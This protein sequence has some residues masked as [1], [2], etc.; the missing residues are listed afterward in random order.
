M[1]L[2]AIFIFGVN[3]V[4][5]TIDFAN[6]YALFLAISLTLNFEFGYT[7]I[8]NFGKVLF[9]AA[10]A[11]IS[12]SISG[13]I[14]A[15]AFNINSHGDIITF[16]AQVITQANTFISGDALFAVSIILFSLLLAGTIGATFGYLASYPAIR[17]R[18]DY[19][20]MLLLA[21]AQFFQIFLSGY[22]PLVGG[23]QGI[24]VPDPYS[25]WAGL[26]TGVRDLVAMLVIGAFAIIV[27]IYVER[28][29]RSPL[30]RTLRALRDNED[31]SK[32]LGKD[33]VAIRKRVLVIASAISGMAGALLTFYAGS[34]GAETWT[35]ITW[36]FWPWV[37]VI[38]GGAGNNVGV[39][40]GALFFT[41]ILKGI[42][43]VKFNFQPYL[44]VDV[45][46]F[47]YLLFASLLIVILMV[48]PEG[49][50]RE[51]PT[52]TISKSTIAS[53]KQSSNTPPGTKVQS[54]AEIPSVWRQRRSFQAL[55]LWSRKTVSDREPGE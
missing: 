8:P 39:A 5:F 33:D 51:K 32:A 15:W 50:I 54:V 2:P 3:I 21:A 53:I 31:A 20:G 42:E 6:F 9:V 40:L 26:G 18:E 46:W 12:G 45:N 43:Q 38:I 29:A 11:A 37:I 16:N 23:T 47:E 25:Y 24:L 34:V 49:I 13:R 55:R 19:L 17:L 27:Y 44:P 48:R 30:G 4:S 52:S 1:A 10:G 41:G 22:E 36:T 14:A 35:R 7:G 28:V